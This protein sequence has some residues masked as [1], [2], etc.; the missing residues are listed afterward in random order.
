MRSTADIG[1]A[2]LGRPLLDKPGK[3]P[4]P[5]K[6]DVETA[7]VDVPALGGLPDLVARVVCLVVVFRSVFFLVFLE[8]IFN[9]ITD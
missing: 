5:G 6:G 1:L 8:G 7:A 2:S 3:K 9:S 4:C